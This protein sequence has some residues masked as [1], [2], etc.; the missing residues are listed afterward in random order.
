MS[1]TASASYPQ[2]IVVAAREIRFD[3][4]LKTHHL[5]QVLNEL[6]VPALPHIASCDLLI[7]FSL[8][9][10]ERDYLCEI[11]VVDRNSRLLFT[12]P[13]TIRNV[14][15]ENRP[16][17]CDLSVRVPFLVEEEGEFAFEIIGPRGLIGRYLL[18]V[19]EEGA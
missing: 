15:P 3:P 2:A 16:A 10:R 18:Y 4:A 17:G 8:E 12:M 6:T 11:C 1:G 19:R 5:E 7:K 14:R 9:D 13:K